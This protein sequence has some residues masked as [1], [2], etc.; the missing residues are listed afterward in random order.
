MN[1]WSVDIKQLKTHKKQY[2]IWHLEQMVNFGLG[3]EKID[4]KQ[5]KKNWSKLDLDIKKKKYL[6][7][8]L[9]PARQF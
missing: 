4:K 5:L 9:W 7:S 1:N 6:A 2:T 3:K 8:L